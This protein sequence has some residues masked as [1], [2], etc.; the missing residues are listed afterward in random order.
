MHT[1]GARTRRGCCWLDQSTR[2]RHFLQREQLER[3]D[4]RTGWRSAPTTELCS[5]RAAGV[6]RAAC[7]RGGLPAAAGTR[8]RP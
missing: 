2:H 1:D 4:L 7:A 5:G 8:K 3:N 6:L